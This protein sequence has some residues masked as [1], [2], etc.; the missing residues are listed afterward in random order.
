MQSIHYIEADFPDLAAMNDKMHKKFNE[1]HEKG[2]LDKLS[3]NYLS[4]ENKHLRIGCMY[5]LPKIHKF[6]TD[7]H[8]KCP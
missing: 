3:L 6:E 7:I 8:R 1:M 2:T 5:L 4:C